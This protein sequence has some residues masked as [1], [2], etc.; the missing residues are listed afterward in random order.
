M[1]LLVKDTP[2]QKGTRFEYLGVPPEKTASLELREKIKNFV[3]GGD[4]WV[5]VKEV[6]EGTGCS[7]PTARDHLDALTDL[8]VLARGKEGSAYVY[9]PSQNSGK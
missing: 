4:E 2:D 8:K 9:G 5:K 1:A 7:K 3:L 6:A